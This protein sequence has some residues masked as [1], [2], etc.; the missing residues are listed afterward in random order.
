MKSQLF[1]FDYT[2]SKDYFDMFKHIFTEHFSLL[3]YEHLKSLFEAVVLKGT[4]D[5]SEYVI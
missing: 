3:R 4:K 5:I 1:V 2:L